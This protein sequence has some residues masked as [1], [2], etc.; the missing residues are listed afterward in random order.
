MNFD[1]DNT[2]TQDDANTRTG[3]LASPPIPVVRGGT[4]KLPLGNSEMPMVVGVMPA[5]LLRQKA[6]IDMLSPRNKQGY[7][8]EANKLRIN[9]LTIALA[10]GEVDL[11]TALLLNVRENDEDL[12]QEKEG[13]FGFLQL[14]KVSKL[15]IVDGQHRY[16]AIKQLVDNDRDRWFN[17]PLHFILIIGAERNQELKQFYQ[18]NNNAKSVETKLALEHLKK[19]SESDPLMKH[20]LEK[21][22]KLWQVQAEEL[23]YKLNEESDA[24]KDR[25]DVVSQTVDKKLTIIKNASMV[26]SFKPL[27]QQRGNFFQRLNFKQRY[28]VVDVYWQAIKEIMPN[29]FATPKKYSLQKGVGVVVLH[30]LLLS[31]MDIVERK[32][33]KDAFYDKESYKPIME[34][35]FGELKGMNENGTEVEGEDFWLVQKE[36]GVAGSYSSEGGMRL[37]Y[38]QMEQI[39][40]DELD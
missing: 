37:L 27:L 31:V 17:Y 20:T 16:E 28:A 39:L 24:W 7:Q 9:K 10:N 30:H 36:G 13:D 11:S 6:S 5:G 2:Q 26:R 18:V 22:D 35:V 33:S 1:H 21:Q 14:D 23:V 8:R 3:H 32:S 29:A 25:I 38:A 19:L 34:K 40:E 12:I 15:W 4:I